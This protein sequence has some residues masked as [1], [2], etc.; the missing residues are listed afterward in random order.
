MAMDLAYIQSQLDL[1]KNTCIEIGGPTPDGYDFIQKLGLHLPAHILVSNISNPIVLNP[2]GDQ[3]EEHAVD[4]VLDI[5]NMP[6]ALHEIDML[7]T[8]SLPKHLR[9]ILFKTAAKVLRPGGILV[10]ENEVAADR[11]TAV[12]AGLTPLID[13]DTANPFHGQIY[14][15]CYTS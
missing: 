2:H 1:C 7:L 15:T 3:P 5:T 10:I 12:Q 8:S 11:A 9:P 13:I 6:Y 4:L 14:Q